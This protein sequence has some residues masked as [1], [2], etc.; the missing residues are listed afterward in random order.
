MYNNVEPCLVLLL[1]RFFT[2]LWCLANMSKYKMQFR[3]PFSVL[4][5]T[6]SLIW[7][8][9]LPEVCHAVLSVSLT[10]KCSEWEE[11][12]LQASCEFGLAVYWD[13]KNVNRL[14]DFWLRA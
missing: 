2:I 12:G 3:C 9:F 8:P 1:P 13:H 6:R 5:R 11:A 14:D 10:N 7:F 4:F